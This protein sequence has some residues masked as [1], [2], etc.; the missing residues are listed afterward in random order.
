MAGADVIFTGLGRGERAGLPLDGF[1]EFIGRLVGTRELSAKSTFKI[2][3]LPRTVNEL[4]LLKPFF[5]YFRYLFK[6]QTQS[7][8]SYLSWTTFFLPGLSFVV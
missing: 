7:L 5:L 3:F 6:V 4:F 2:T 8:Y 1:T